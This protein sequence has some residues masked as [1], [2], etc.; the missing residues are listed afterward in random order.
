LKKVEEKSVR[1]ARQ[2]TTLLVHGASERETD[3]VARGRDFAADGSAVA[4]S[5][6]SAAG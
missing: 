6:I 2:V 1:P 4:E 5:G 3:E